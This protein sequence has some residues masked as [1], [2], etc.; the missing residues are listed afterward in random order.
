[1]RVGFKPRAKHL[2]VTCVGL[3]LEHK[4]PTQIT[5]TFDA[6]GLKPTQIKVN[7]LVNML[8]VHALEN[9]RVNTIGDYCEYSCE[10]SCK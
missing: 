8:H 2:S 10:Y 1:M 7:A 6:L 9:T 5:L 4:K 3:S